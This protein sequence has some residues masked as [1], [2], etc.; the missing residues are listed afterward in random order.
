MSLLRPII[1][2]CAVG[3]LREQTWADSRV[4]DTDMT[5]LGEAVF[6]KA[7]SPYIVVFTDSDDIIP[8]KGV[9]EIYDGDNRALSLLIEIGVASSIQRKTPGEYIIKFSHTDFGMEWAVDIV[10]S[11]V[12]AALIGNPKSEWGRLFKRMVYKLRTLRSRRG[13]MKGGITFAAR[14]MTLVYNTNNEI[15]P[16]I[17]PA[18]THPIWKFIE[19]AKDPQYAAL[20]LAELAGNVEKLLDVANAPT[21]RQAQTLLGVTGKMAKQLAV[22]GAPLP[23]PQEEKEPLDWSD[24]NEYVPPLTDVKVSDVD[25]NA[26][27]QNDEE[28]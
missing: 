28:E 4:F 27:F 2:A 21:W 16:G 19:M 13:G 25:P 7:A 5:P 23:W 11:Q 22:D 8:V 1:R 24:T 15:A 12:L 10:Q 20:G 26:G 17:I 6:G 18:E 3:A 9:A 14:R